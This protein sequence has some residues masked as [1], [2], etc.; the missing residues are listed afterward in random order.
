M[1]KAAL[2]LAAFLLISSMA[3]SPCFAARYDLKTMTPQVDQALK[4][5]QAR[6]VQVQSLKQAGAVG[7][8]NRGYLTV[9]KES[10]SIA[11]LIAEENS[12]RGI[13]YRALVDQNA[14]GPNGMTEVEK[15]FAE[16]QSEKAAQGEMVQSPPGEWVRK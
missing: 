15:A 4:S 16:V 2:L 8:N 6:F 14:L 11:G 13:I 5:R 3:I 10:P 12:D 9:L 7:E 1:K